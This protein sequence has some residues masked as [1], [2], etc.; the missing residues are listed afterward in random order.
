MNVLITGTN[1]GIGFYLA[2]EF[3]KNNFTVIALDRTYNN[4]FKKEKNYNFISFNLEKLEENNL[5]QI[6]LKIPIDIAILNAGIAHPLQLLST[7]KQSN[8]NNIFNIN[9][10]ANKTIIDLLID[11]TSV[12]QI[13][14]ISSG[15]VD[16]YSKGW[17]GYYLSKILLNE[18]ISIYAIEHQSIHFS[19]IYPHIIKTKMTNM[20]IKT[21]NKDIFPSILYLKSQRL[22]NLDKEAKLIYTAIKNIKNKK[23]GI[24]IHLDEII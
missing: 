10:W 8:L 1:S 24:N 3:I 11:K 5:E 6:F 4:F 17:G 22:G 16:N 19:S 2:K 20:L 13:I 23:S 12:K 14:A 9:V 18:L 21:T 7:I 15:I